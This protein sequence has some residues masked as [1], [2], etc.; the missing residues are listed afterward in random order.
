MEFR[1]VKHTEDDFG[2]Y[3]IDYGVVTEDALNRIF[4]TSNPDDD[5]QFK[6]VM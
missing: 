5:I 6:E 2:P 1:V 4:E 3:T